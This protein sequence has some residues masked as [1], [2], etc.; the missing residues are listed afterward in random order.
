VAEE[1]LRALARGRLRV[2]AG[3]QNRL[4]AAAQG[5]VPRA[6]VRAVAGRLFRPRPGSA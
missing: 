4:V 3:W 5:L 1:S 2:I 6:W